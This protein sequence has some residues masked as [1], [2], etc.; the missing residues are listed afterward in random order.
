MALRKDYEKMVNPTQNEKTAHLLKLQCD[1]ISHSPHG[2]Y[3][4]GKVTGLASV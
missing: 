3:K 2:N 1:A 4:I